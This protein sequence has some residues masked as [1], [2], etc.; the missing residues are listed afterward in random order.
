MLYTGKGDKGTTRV[1]DSK[2]RFSKGSD[3][4]EALGS[5]DELNSFIGLCKF[6]ARQMQDGGVT[7]G[8]KE[9]KT[10]DILRQ[11]QENLF[12]IQ[13][14]VAGADKKINKA[15]V[16]KLEKIIDTIEQE[17]P[18]L[19]GFS[20]AGGTELSSL[21]DIARTLARRTERRVVLVKE[22]GSRKLPGYTLP[23]LN[24]LSSLLFALAR[25]SNHRSGVKEKRP[26]YK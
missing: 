8:H 2:E 10:S 4:A 15:K 19:K 26:S 14:Q 16:T 24:R 1:I 11:A 21:L 7:V 20:I 6:K 18:P 25:L 17:I 12:I 9:E 5:L 3:L 22:M 13:A 23:Y